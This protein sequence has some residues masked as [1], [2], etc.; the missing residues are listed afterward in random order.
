MDSF[1][2]LSHRL[3]YNRTR[4]GPPRWS[5]NASMD[6][7]SGGEAYFALGMEW[8][9]WRGLRS[10]PWRPVYARY[11]PVPAVRPKAAITEADFQTETLAGQGQGKPS[12]R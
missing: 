6:A 2:E 4:D 10:F 1:A 11:P 3:G 5:A 12:R 7:P 9:L 8:R